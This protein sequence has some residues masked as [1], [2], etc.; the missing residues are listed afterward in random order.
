[1]E[2]LESTFI[3]DDGDYENDNGKKHTL[4]NKIET[5]EYNVICCMFAL[6]CGPV[7]DAL[8]ALPGAVLDDVPSS[9]RTSCLVLVVMLGS[10]AVRHDRIYVL[11]QRAIL[12]ILLGSCAFI[13]LNEAEVSARNSDA[14]FALVGTLACIVA[15]YSNG[16]MEQKEKDS[17]KANK[18]HMSSL[19][20]A[21]FF[22]LGIRTI[23]HSFALS[24]EVLNFKVSHDD[25]SVMGYGMSNDMVVVGNSFAG[26]CTVAFACI[27]LLNHDL[28]LHVGSSSMSN[29]AS[30]FACF[31][32][33]G[34]FVA[35]MASFTMMERLPALFSETSCN[36]DA[37]ECQAAYRARRLFTSSNSTSVPWTCA[38]ALVIYAFSH[39]R[40][41]RTRKEHFEY[42][43]DLYGIESMA[44]I[45][46]AICCI[47][48]ILLFAD[49]NSSMRWT[50]VELILLVA[51]IPVC[52]LGFPFVAC[53][54]HVG[55]QALYIWGRIEY[56]GGYNFSYFTHHSLLATLVLTC[57][58][59]LLSLFSHVLYRVSPRRLYSEPVE[60]FN[61]AVMT[62]L[63]SVQTF[64]TL[65]TIG[66]TSGYTGTY[67]SKGYFGW[68][69]SG[70]EFT[71]QHCVSF[72]FVA[73]L[74]ATR[75]EHY[76][77]SLA[78]R[79]AAWFVPP[80]LLGLTWLACIS[81]ESSGS[82]YEQYV[83]LASFV[84]GTT[85]AAA[86]WIGVGV[87]LHV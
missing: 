27:A 60:K 22:Y 70:Y 26:G 49:S 43:P 67:Y 37:K 61:G 56:I 81:A 50:D 20:A 31:V 68:R 32:F 54:A 80:P 66:M 17:S 87:F 72:F 74:Y 52:L 13:G 30:V 64:L 5:S 71:V 83:D 19:C 78:I 44:C 51:S 1:M 33:L 65:G 47:F 10:P 42:T 16:V 46:S 59:A 18:E 24:S 57:V 6:L 14:V 41:F 15:S 21:M 35:Q 4:T 53:C 58:T 63:V 77:L 23:R 39:T 34:A 8:C 82:P 2:P 85:A 7:L 79:R 25:I 11:E 69:V 9:L 86:S 29:I 3:P 84:I 75:Y 45:L 12:A 62:S 48:V 55:G 36:G 38:I 73:C 40:K 76:K 28:V